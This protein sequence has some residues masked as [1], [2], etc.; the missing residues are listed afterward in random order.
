MEIVAFSARTRQDVDQR[1][2]QE[3]FERMLALVAEI[4][5]FVDIRA[6][7]GED[8]S[9]LALVRFESREAIDAWREHPKHVKTREQGRNEF[10]SAYE[11][12]IASV[13]KSYDWSLETTTTDP[14][15]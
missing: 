1:E 15:E 11:I 2:Y 14:P 13:W 9:E 5:G 3:T 8:G 6:Y 4:P 12:T 7:T 10:F